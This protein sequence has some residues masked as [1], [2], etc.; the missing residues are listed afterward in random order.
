MQTTS[1]RRTIATGGRLMNISGMAVAALAALLV[2]AD[3][4]ALTGKT[5]ELTKLGGEKPPARGITATFAANG[6]VSGF[7]GCNTYSGAYVASARALRISK[8][9]ST[10]KACAESAMRTESAYLHALGTTRSYAVASGTLTLADRSGRDV[11]SFRTQSQSLEGTRWQ[12]TGYNN[13]KGA[14]ASVM[15]ATKLTAVFGKHD[16]SG[17]AG[18]N[19]Y[20]GPVKT[21]PP[22]I[23]IGP[24]S[25]TNKACGSPAG[26]MDQ[27]AGYL[28]ALGTA[29]TYRL[30]GSELELRTAK[31][32]IAVTF[33]RG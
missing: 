11:A 28:A 4:P 17:F 1:E 32:A 30:E 16:V 19:D 24:L 25:S 13:G 18:C 5:W 10:K 8:L 27:E 22:K 7:S 3:G 31:G 12:V 33:Q 26:V 23:A 2:G 15:A 29:A 6:T 9:A 21:S 14:V 20:S